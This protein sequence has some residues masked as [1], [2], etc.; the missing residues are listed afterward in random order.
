M[1]HHAP[2]PPSAA[3]KAAL[4]LDH[5][6]AVAVLTLARGVCDNPLLRLGPEVNPLVAVPALPVQR[7]TAAQL[8]SGLKHAVHNSVSKNIIRRACHHDRLR[9][10]MQQHTKLLRPNG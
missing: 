3:L 8:P 1:K 10:H 6:P 2:R 9:R 4:V 5:G 7:P